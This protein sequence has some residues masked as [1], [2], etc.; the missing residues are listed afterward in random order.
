MPKQQL[1]ASERARREVI[2]NDIHKRVAENGPHQALPHPD[3]ARQFMPF[4][5]LKGYHEM[6]ASIEDDDPDGIT[7]S[8][9]DIYT[10]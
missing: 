10:P 1:S 7:F 8:S 5:A 2:L 3:R 6:A 9:E 4:A